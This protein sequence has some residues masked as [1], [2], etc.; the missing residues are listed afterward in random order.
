MKKTCLTG[1]RLLVKCNLWICLSLL[2]GVILYGCASK[3]YDAS[4]TFS[5]MQ[6]TE[7]WVDEKDYTSPKAK[8]KSMLYTEGSYKYFSEPKTVRLKS[9]DYYEAITTKGPY[10]GVFI[11]ISV[12]RKEAKEKGLVDSN[13]HLIIDKILESDELI[14]KYVVISGLNE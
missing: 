8:M 10:L 2:F 13:G 4:L 6:F 14:E 7:K 1:K 11:I 3:T 5:E 12:P 9:M